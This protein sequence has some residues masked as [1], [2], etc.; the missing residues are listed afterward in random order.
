M[1]VKVSPDDIRTAIAELASG[2]CIGLPT[3]TVYGL[4]ADATNGDAVARIFE[5]KERP[6]FNPLIAHVS[7][8]EMAMT[9][10]NFDPLSIRLAETFWPGPLTLIL[11]VRQNSPVHPLVTAGLSTIGL[12]CPQGLS[13]KLIDMFGKPLAA[14]SANRSGRIS[15]TRADHVTEEFADTDLVVIDGPACDTGIESTI[16]KVEDETITIL[17][18]GSVTSQMIR[19]ATGIEPE[20][21]RG[22][23]I[24]APGMMKS[25]YAPDAVLLT[26]QTNPPD[27]AC[28]LAFG[29]QSAETAKRA[30]HIFNLSEAGDLREAAANLYHGLKLL[31]A[32]G[33]PQIHAQP[34]PETGLGDAIN[35]RL[36]RAAA[37][38]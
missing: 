9:H 5:M 27:G 10:G 2:K 15:P 37:P 32:T 35:D 21:Y 28:I 7:G 24:E 22:E 8:L 16:A 26:N 3:E 25:H 18:P 20:P 33:A 4:A 11:P 30:K 6:R 36:S 1:A 23:G 17:R 19:A 38:R 14:P 12:R 29:P 31:D 34:V 13:P